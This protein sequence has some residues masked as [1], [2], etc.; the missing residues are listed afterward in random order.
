MGAFAEVMPGAVV[1]ANCNIGG[2]A[3]VE[4][5]AWLSDGVTVKNN[6]LVWGAGRA[7]GPAL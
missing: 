5:G 4:S 1:G 2:G 6:V 3:F 7:S